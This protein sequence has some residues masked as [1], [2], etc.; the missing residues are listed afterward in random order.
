MTDGQPS[1]VATYLA[2]HHQYGSNPYGG[3]SSLQ[4]DK[5][6]NNEAFSSILIFALN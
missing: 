2:D 5:K 1:V 3:K 4:G 6:Y